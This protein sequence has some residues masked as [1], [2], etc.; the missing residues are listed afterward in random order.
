MVGTCSSGTL[1]VSTQQANTSSRRRRPH[2]ETKRQTT[3]MSPA[4]LRRLDCP[5]AVSHQPISFLGRCRMYISACF[6]AA[7]DCKHCYC[8]PFH[9]HACIYLA[10]ARIIRMPIPFPSSLKSW[11]PDS[12]ALTVSVQP[13]TKLSGLELSRW[14]LALHE[15]RSTTQQVRKPMTEQLPHTASPFCALSSTGCDSSF[16]LL[17]TETWGTNRAGTGTSLSISV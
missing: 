15:T 9:N 4:C 2:R 14:I 5:P 8:S 3:W 10:A 7:Q 13:P 17:P 1:C 11:R 6:A 12:V 16:Y